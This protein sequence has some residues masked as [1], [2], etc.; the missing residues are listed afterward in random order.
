[1][2]PLTG[3]VRFEWQIQQQDVGDRVIFM[4][5]YVEKGKTKTTLI[6]LQIID[7][8]PSQPI[9]QT[10]KR[11]ITI[12]TKRDDDSGNPD[13]YQVSI[14]SSAYTLPA[15]VQI[16]PE[17]N[18]CRA[19]P[20]DW[21][22]PCKD[23]VAQI[24]TPPDDIIAQKEWVR[25]EA[26]NLQD[27][28]AVDL[29]CTSIRCIPDRTSRSFN[30]DVRWTWTIVKGGGR[31]LKGNVGRFVIY[32]APQQETEVEIEV[33]ID[34]PY[35]LQCSDD[36]PPPDKI[37]LRIV[38]PGIR[39]ELTDSTW[40]PLGGTAANTV[41]KR[42]YLVYKDGDTWVDARPHMCRIHKFELLNTT[43]ESGFCLN[44]GNHN[45]TSL[46]LWIPEGANH[47]CSDEHPFAGRAEKFYQ[48]AETK[49]PVREYTLTVECE[50][51]GAWAFLRS[52]VN[53]PYESVPWKRSEVPRVVEGFALGGPFGVLP[54]MSPG[55]VNEQGDNRVTIPFDADENRIADA[56][57]HN[58]RGRAAD[59]DQDNQPVGEGPGDGLSNYEEY[60]GFLTKGTHNRT[61]IRRKDL[62]IHDQHNL[63][64]GYFVNASQLRCHL[65][66]PAEYNGDNVRQVN[67]NR[68]YASRCAQHGLHLVNINLGAG[69]LGYTPGCQT[70]SR[71]ALDDS[72]PI[73]PPK[74][75]L[76]VRVDRSKHFRLQNLAIGHGIVIAIPV[77][78][79]D[80]SATIAH[81]LGHAVSMEH[82]GDTDVSTISVMSTTGTQR[83]L[84]VIAAGGVTSGREDCLMRYNYSNYWWR[85][86]TA[87]P[88]V[89][90]PAGS[91]TIRLT[92]EADGRP[93]NTFCDSAVGTGVNAGGQAGGNASRGDCRGQIH[94]S[95]E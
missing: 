22:K 65:I 42:S 23:L 18:D 73:G 48:K 87:V 31:F 49:R 57:R 29:I 46:D 63:G 3:K 88:I 10:V 30:D 75:V 20:P 24:L 21:K 13:V 61:D 47:E 60:R 33:R 86:P 95:D 44:G 64:L 12:Q 40:L 67:F 69:T 79:E 5:P 71:T 51:Y 74:Y 17:L 93:I 70:N 4:P 83:R 55:L 36:V 26:V 62:F 92:F 43:T 54:V 84:M 37:K 8:N 59:R 77:A 50:D 16:T 58:D 89:L 81:E 25:L 68:G 72:T 15:A 56:T 38:K 11:W 85:D 2:R 28:D 45:D 53:A 78:T 41:T 39:M 35:G 91:G 52:T 7:D 19:E 66:D 32:E 1:M 9:D 94:V 80:L 76:Q 82:H 14:S 27:P 90:W 34:N 6:L